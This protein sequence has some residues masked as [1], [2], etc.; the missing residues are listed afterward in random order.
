MLGGPIPVDSG[1]ISISNL[2]FV[3]SYRVLI[4]WRALIGSYLPTTM[5]I[6]STTHPLYPHM[7]ASFNEIV[8][9]QLFLGKYVVARL[10]LSLA[11]IFSS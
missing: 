4:C 8:K 3:R 2:S 1:V 7:P 9:G 10:C 5:T 6:K 11:L